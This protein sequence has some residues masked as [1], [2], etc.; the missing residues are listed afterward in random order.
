MYLP[1]LHCYRALALIALDR[2]EEAD[3]LLRACIDE[4]E[5]ALAEKDYGYFATTT[6]FHSFRERPA[7]ARKVHYAFLLGLAHAVLGE[8]DAARGYFRAVLNEDPGHLLATME[9]EALAG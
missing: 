6:Y 5:A 4:W 2:R 7:R 1:S 3:E 9:L 8:A